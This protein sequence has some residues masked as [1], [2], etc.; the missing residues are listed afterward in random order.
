MVRY[1]RPATTKAEFVSHYLADH[2]PLLAKLPEIRSVLCYLPL[3]TLATP[4]L[5]SADIMIGNEVAFDSPETQRRNG[6]AGSR[7][8]ARTLPHISQVHRPQHALSD[9][10]RR[11][12][13]LPRGSHS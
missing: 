13:H 2:P 11:R 8:T 7:R 6:L 1:H 5:P 12:I 3:E 4:A 9:D 10:A